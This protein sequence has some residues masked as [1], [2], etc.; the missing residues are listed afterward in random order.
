M[1]AEALQECEGELE[2]ALAR[3]ADL[4]AT[5]QQGIVERAGLQ[6]EIT[7]LQS[8]APENMLGTAGL[9]A[10]QRKQIAKTSENVAWGPARKAGKSQSLPKPVQTIS[11]ARLAT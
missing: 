11:G 1:N 8:L 6:Q 4:Q 7:R 9:P 10:Q 5:V 2:Q 3:V